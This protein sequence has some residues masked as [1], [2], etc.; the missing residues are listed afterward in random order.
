M[1]FGRL[2]FSC[3]TKVLFGFSARGEA[4]VCLSLVK[5]IL[6]EKMFTGGDVLEEAER[7]VQQRMTFEGDTRVGGGVQHCAAV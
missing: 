2:Q 4:Y 3:G 1:D 5:R 7:R 6:G